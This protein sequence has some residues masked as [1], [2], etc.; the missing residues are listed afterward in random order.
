MTHPVQ[1]C[2]REVLD[3]ADRLLRELPPSVYTA[4]PPDGGSSI[5]QHM[6][7]MLDHFQVLMQ[8]DTELLDYDQRHRGSCIETDI[9]QARALIAHIQAWLNGLDDDAINAE[10]TVRSEVSL[11]KTVCAEVGSSLGRELM[12]VSSHMV[13]HQAIVAMLAKAMSVEVEPGL[14]LAPAT[15]TYL[16]AIG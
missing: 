14:G 4:T 2:T 8:A 9:E 16:R 10:V 12:F 6:R 3:Q 7:H 5:G 15:R 13:H 1:S 11:S